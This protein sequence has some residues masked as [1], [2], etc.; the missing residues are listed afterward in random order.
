[1]YKYEKS[2]LYKTV[3]KVIKISYL[4]KKRYGKILLDIITYS[5]SLT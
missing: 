4:P 3:N 5:R 1:M 2:N